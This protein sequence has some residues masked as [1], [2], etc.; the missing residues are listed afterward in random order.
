M[1]AAT[2]IGSGL[3][4]EA[5]VTQLV[6]AERTPAESRL[7]GQEAVLTAELSAFGSYKGALASFQSSLS[8]LNS[9]STFSQRLANSGDEDIATLTASS[10]AATANYDLAVTQ[11]AKS[12]SLA[13]GSYS[14][15]ADVVGTGTIT[16]RFGTTDYTSPDPG[17]ESYNSFTVNPDKGVATITVDSSNNTLEGLRNAINDADIG[18]S[19]AIVNDGSG[20]RLLLNS[21]STGEDNSLEIS[22]DDSGDG[23]DL[24]NSGLSSLAFNSGATNLSQTVAAQ[25][26]IFS[27]NGLSINSNENT[28]NDVIDG[29]DITLKDLTGATP[30]S[31]SISEDQAGVKEAITDFVGAYNSFVETVNNLTS[32]DPDTGIAG[33]LQGDFSARS[34]TSQLRQ[35]LSNAVEGFGQ[36][37]FSSLSEI[38]IT[39]QSDGTLNVDS[40]DLDAVLAS[41][42]DE[43]VGMFA[44]VGFPSDDNIDF[45]SSS[46]ET[47]V[48]SHAIN[49]SQIA[50][51][52]QLVGAAAGFPL[53]IDDDNDALTI[54]VDGVTSNS[55]TLT[56]GTYANGA[57][58]AAELQAR[59]NGDAALAAAGAKVT[60]EFNTD[61]FE[62]T[63]DRYGS[64]SNVEVT[65]IDTNTTAELGFSVATGTGGLDVA[66]TIGGV[67]AIGS[68]Q[69]LTGSVGSDG[70]G[71]QIRIQGGATGDRGTVD[72]SQGIAY[73]L[74][75]MIT[76]FLE[77]D[78]TLD[79]RT[80]GIQDRIEDIGDQR[81]ALD[82]RMELLEARYRSQF[83]ALDGLL[84]QLQTTSDFL[85][86]QLAS[87]PDPGSLVNGNN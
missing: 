73:Q 78:G 83:N 51:Q 50:T 27:I 58:L 60:V 40:G 63:S 74:N 32:Y 28:V 45:V 30:V 29:V 67:A 76:A 20:Y 72:F 81:E 10:E 44:A 12:H 24:N 84:A 70:E 66:G 25:D 53:D 8:Q 49:I 80:D 3:D 65:A 55:I 33:A 21:S 38:G 77:A 31:L 41:N 22:V 86:Q 17:P 79:S 64:A 69:L 13:S 75:T 87:L 47:A 71:L 4:I 68:G 9:L 23:D 19:A 46:D 42:F 52:G 2:G 59:I 1:V 26:A 82:Y 61:H 37:T 57:D 54:K 39:T 14:S 48:A 43:I 11:L 34:I 6:A 16:I 56:Q 5:L 18:V 15:A 36:T 35:V 85:T 7:T 62:I